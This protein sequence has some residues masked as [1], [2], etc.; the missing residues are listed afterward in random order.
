V[1]SEIENE[2]SQDVQQAKLAEWL[3]QARAK[4]KIE[5]FI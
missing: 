1:R 3:Q 4:A 5:I 2:L